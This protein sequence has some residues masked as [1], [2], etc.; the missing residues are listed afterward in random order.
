MEQHE[1][2]AKL[3]A[4]RTVLAER[5]DKSGR[6]F[7]P[8]FALEYFERYAPLRDE[9]RAQLPSLFGE[10]PVRAIPTPSDTTD[11]GGRGYIRREELER[12]M[13]D[14]NYVLNVLRGVS[15]ADVP[16]MELTKEGVFFSGQYYDAF[17]QV[18]GIVAS[19]QESITLIDR[20]VGRETFELLGGKA[21]T[22]VLRVLTKGLSDSVRALARAFQKQ[23]GGLEIRLSDEFHDRFLIIDDKAFYHFG[24]SIKDLGKRGFMFSVIE[25]P[26]VLA[27]IRAK[28]QDEWSRATVEADLLGS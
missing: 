24:A 27:S 9:L 14:M 22:V 10:L 15:S 23:H 13:G 19:A 25:E 21:E 2:V 3:K 17:C 4:L 28:F 11:F 12:L 18:A 8:D 1:V 6:F 20:Y 5:L 7:N 26:D 16:T